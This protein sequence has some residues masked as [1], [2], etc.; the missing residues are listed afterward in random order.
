[1]PII[2]LRKEENVFTGKTWYSIYKDG[3]YV[4]GT[5]TQDQTQAETF[6]QYCKENSAVQPTVNVIKSETV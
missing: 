4:S 5:A 3:A 2:E 6:F 1:M